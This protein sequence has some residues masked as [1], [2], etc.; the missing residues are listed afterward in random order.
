[1]QSPALR[2]PN[3]SP[4]SAINAE[5]RFPY[6]S[7]RDYT[8]ERGGRDLPP[9]ML[10]APMKHPNV[11]LGGI[12]VPVHMLT[13]SQTEGPNNTVHAWTDKKYSKAEIR[14][15]RHDLDIA[16]A[17]G[18]KNRFG[19]RAKADRTYMRQVANDYKK[20]EIGLG[21]YVRSKIFATGL[22]NLH[23][24]SFDDDAKRRRLR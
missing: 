7:L 18:K 17:Q 2:S 16:A 1:M 8:A 19:L 12:E 6:K 14:A 11:K 3:I 22:Q 5:P 4:A 15:R 24:A 20:G 21:Q 9:L 10:E 23:Y 13:G